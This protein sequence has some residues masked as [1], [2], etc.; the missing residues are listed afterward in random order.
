MSGTV[1]A[2]TRNW[3][4][5]VLSSAVSS[6]AV[7]GLHVGRAG[8][9]AP[10]SWLRPGAT[11]R[12]VP[13]RIAGMMYSIVVAVFLSLPA[14]PVLADDAAEA[15]RLMVE[16]VRDIRHADLEPSAEGKFARLKRAHDKLLAIVQRYPST[17]L[18]VKLATG[19]R[20]GNISLAAG[21]P[22]WSGHGP[23]D[24]LN[25]ARRSRSGGMKRVSSRWRCHPAA[26]GRGR[27]AATVSECCAMSLRGRCS[28]PGATPSGPR[29]LPSR[30]MGSAC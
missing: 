5:R 15:N 7:H 21:A 1:G 3:A 18:A 6:E 28:A 19:Q 10:R 22:P 17:D 11:G 13:R 8:R 26:G 29:R 9:D 25:R 20:V 2:P 30:P 23:L 27:Y 12:N 4:H 24:A 16:A 14:V